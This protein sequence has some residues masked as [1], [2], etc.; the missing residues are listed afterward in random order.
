MTTRSQLQPK[1]TT[2]KRF[3]VLETTVKQ[4]QYNRFLYALVGEKWAW[5]DKLSWSNEQW[6]TY[7]ESENLRT[8]VAYYDGS[9]AGYFELVLQ[10][11]EVEIAFFGLA[12]AFIGKGLGGPLLTHAIEEAWSMK[13]KRVWVHTCTLDHPA[14][15]RNYQ[16]RG[17][18]VF[19]T[20]VKGPNKS[21]HRIADKPG[22]R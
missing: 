5:R 6:R 12:P 8:F 22:S 4:W 17:M 9:P 13:P 19:R 18:V 7:A 10:E 21:V 2:D 20:E 3:R 1:R 16:S 11:E 14:A 15:L